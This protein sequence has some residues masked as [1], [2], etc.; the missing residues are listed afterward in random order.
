MRD[1]LASFASLQAFFTRALRDGRAADRPGAPTR[2]SRPATARGASRARVEAGRLLQVKGRPYALADLLAS[3]EDAAR[4]EGGAFATFYLA[5]A[6]LP[7][8]PRAL[9][10]ARRARALSC[11]GAL[12]PVNRI[13]LEG[14]DGLFAQNERIC[15]CM[16]ARRGRR[17]LCLVAVGATMVG[18]VRVRFDS[19]ETNLPGARARG[20]RPTRTAS[21]LAKGEEWGRFEFGS[22]LSSCRAGRDCAGRKTARNSADAS[23]SAS[24]LY[25]R[26]V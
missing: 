26:A 23:A 21:P 14:V 24:G 4:F 6:R 1:P 9:R 22:T 7:P 10:R 5:A 11:P 16:R 12:W 25:A 13:G 2:W 17:S 18:K 19:L 15:A 8:L 3:R 20:A